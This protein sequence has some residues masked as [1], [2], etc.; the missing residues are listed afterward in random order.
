MGR[1]GTGKRRRSLGN[2]ACRVDVEC[3]LAPPIT[4]VRVTCTRR[5]PL[6][7]RTAG[8]WRPAAAV[9][10]RRHERRVLLLLPLRAARWGPPPGALHAVGRRTPE[11]KLARVPAAAPHHASQGPRP[12]ISTPAISIDSARLL[13]VSE[14][15]VQSRSPAVPPQGPPRPARTRT[16]PCPRNAATMSLGRPDTLP[17]IHHYAAKL[18]SAQQLQMD[19]DAL[20]YAAFEDRLTQ[21]VHELR[22]RV[23]QQQRA[24][25]EVATTSAAVPTVQCQ[26]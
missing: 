12:A 17:S 25:N 23:E 15:L 2:P 11:G 6:R 18:R 13:P 7:P 20:D 4:L 1:A 5:Q 8:A 19:V 10:C 26:R 9:L 22:Q 16:V 24:L 3:A 21:T 14:R